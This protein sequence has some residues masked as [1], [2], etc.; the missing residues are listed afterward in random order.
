M[1]CDLFLGLSIYIIVILLV[2]EQFIKLKQHFIVEENGGG[3]NPYLK[4]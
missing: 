1:D 3:V 4:R 2:F